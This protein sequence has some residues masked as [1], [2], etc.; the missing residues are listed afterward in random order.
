MKI[1]KDPIKR[2][3]SRIS[4]G[5]SPAYLISFPAAGAISWISPCRLE[6]AAAVE[7]GPAAAA[8][9]GRNFHGGDPQPSKA[10]D[11]TKLSLEDLAADLNLGPVSSAIDVLIGGPPSRH[12]CLLI[13][14]CG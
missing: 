11:I 6:I 9:H 14:H 3:I 4:N 12:A 5:E 8:S 1:Q 7:L 13:K 2:K 10:R